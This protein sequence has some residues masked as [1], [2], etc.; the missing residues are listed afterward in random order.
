MEDGIVLSSVADI[1]KERI[2]RAITRIQQ[3]DDVK[4]RK[5]NDEAFNH[6]GVKVFKLSPSNYRSWQGCDEKDFDAYTQEMALFNDPLVDDWK[7]R[8][9]HL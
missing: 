6:I 1:S 3:K 9:C 2:R 4:P 7:C 8:R 5:E